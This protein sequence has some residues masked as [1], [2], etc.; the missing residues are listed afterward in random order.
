[1]VALMKEGGMCLENHYVPASHYAQQYF[2]LMLSRNSLLNT[3]FPIIA[4]KEYVQLMK[5]QIS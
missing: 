3:L 1:M 5:S 4:S 2:S